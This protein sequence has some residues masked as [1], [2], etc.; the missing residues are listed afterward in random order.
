MYDRFI[1]S[2]TQAGSID[3]LKENRHARFDVDGS[4][5]ILFAR[6]HDPSRKSTE[7]T[8]GDGSHDG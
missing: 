5:R 8:S 7:A 3:R 2:Q 1:A 6:M 4:E